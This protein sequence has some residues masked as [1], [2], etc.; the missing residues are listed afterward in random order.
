[1]LGHGAGRGS[2]SADLV[3]LARALPPR[4]IAVVRIDQPWVVSGH[5]IAPR[6][7]M[8]DVAWIETIAELRDRGLVADILVVGGRSA[9][10]RV[11]CRTASTVAADA[12]VAVG[13]PL[14]PPSARGSSAPR[15]AELV[16]ASAAGSRPVLVVQGTRDRFGA[17]T[18]FEPLD[19]GSLVVRGLPYADHSL[20]V[21]ARAPISS[22]E[23]QELLVEHVVE[24][25]LAVADRR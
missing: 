16:T 19:A 5:K 21:P 23:I 20:R 7:E 8:L 18:D 22:A 12:V 2:D 17:P 9:G 4:G 3:A 11:A 25:S 1:M 6:P 13:F 15:R 10:A 24:F 14:T